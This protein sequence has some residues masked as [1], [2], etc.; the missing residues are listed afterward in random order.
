MGS[1][2]GSRE[3]KLR[4]QDILTCIEKVEGYT[5]SMTFDQFQQDART[6]DAVIRNFEV[7]GEAAGY[8]PA[9]IQ[10][11]NP[12]IGWLELRGMRN[13]M[14]HEYFSV[15]LPIIWHTVIHDLPDL[16]RKISALLDK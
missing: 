6:I 16:Y 2:S 7:I 3:W 13:L 11:Q 12:G 5:D 4:V 10:E 15:S 14:I 1:K 8:I 9:E